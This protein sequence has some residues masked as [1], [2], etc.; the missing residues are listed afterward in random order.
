MK[1][2]III[3]HEPLSLRIK[4][5]FCIEVLI[6]RNV[7]VEYWDASQYFFPGSV[8]PDVEEQSYVKQFECLEDIKKA[9]L[10]ADIQNTIFVVEVFNNLKNRKFFQ[11]LKKEKCLCVKWDFYAVL[12]P[13]SQKER[14]K[15]IIRKLFTKRA[16]YKIVQYLYIRFIQTYP[17]QYI[18]SS[19]AYS[20]RTNC[21]NHPDYEEFFENSNQE[22]GSDYIVFLDVYYPLH[23]DYKEEY[24]DISVKDYRTLMRNY[25][26]FVEQKYAM[27]VVIAAHPKSMYEGD[28]FGKR[29]IVKYKTK[30][31]V[32]FASKVISHESSTL[33]YIAL[34]D[35]PFALVHPSSYR[36]DLLDY[37]TALASFCQKKLYNLN[38]DRWDDIQYKPLDRKLRHDYIYNLL[39]SK[40]TES[41]RNVD[42]I[43]DF[44]KKIS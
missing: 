11:F 38:T 5:I 44:I 36:E 26:D 22:I 29:Q 34:A 12:V 13:F 33:T 3:G 31:L 16:F 9:I 15:T 43:F 7:E 4:K 14:I 32:K 19:S 35:K 41:K 25:F 24:S 27:P 1:K 23:P 20:K 28:E 42:I 18:L 6:K 2:V 17:F 40:E 30:N 8:I 37:M 39:T 10:L 21:I